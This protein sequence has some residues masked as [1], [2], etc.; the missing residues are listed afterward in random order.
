MPVQ[1]SEMGLCEV[2]LGLER[3]LGIQLPVMML[4]E[5]PTVQ[6]VTQRIVERLLGGAGDDT[7]A[8]TLDAVAQGMAQQ[9][10]ESVTVEELRQI[11]RDAR[12]M[13]KQGARL[14]A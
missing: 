6:R 11:T 12:A 9:H 2:P 13:A 14:T 1:P 10:G 8:N 4:N 5:S 3:R 7:A